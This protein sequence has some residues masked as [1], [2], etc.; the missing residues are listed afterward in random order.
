MWTGERKHR[1]YYDLLNSI[2]HCSDYENLLG[3][4]L[5]IS[6]TAIATLNEFTYGYIGIY[7]FNMW[8]LINL[9]KEQLGLDLESFAKHAKR[10]TI[11]PDE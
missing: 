2:T 3:T 7:I 10:I 4:S 11:Q 6:K 9:I 8:I 5:N 1:R